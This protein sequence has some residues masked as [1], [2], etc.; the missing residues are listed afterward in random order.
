MLSRVAVAVQK[1]RVEYRVKQILGSTPDA[2]LAMRPRAGRPEPTEAE[3]LA[4]EDHLEAIVA[5]GGVY[6][7]VNLPPGDPYASESP[8][9]PRG[10]YPPYLEY[11]IPVPHNEFFVRWWIVSPTTEDD[12]RVHPWIHSEAQLGSVVS[13]VQLGR[14]GVRDNF[15]GFAPESW[16]TVRPEDIDQI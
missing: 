14:L 5:W 1:G 3:A 13:A 2:I 15:D 10:Y 9:L 6:L 8:P 16:I 7:L 12:Y 11:V 4:S